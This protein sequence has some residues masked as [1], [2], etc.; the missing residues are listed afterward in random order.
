L[1][2][3]R[4]SKLQELESLQ[5]TTAEKMWASELQDLKKDVIKELKLGKSAAT[6][7]NSPK[8]VSHQE[9]SLEEL[10]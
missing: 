6:P 2:T 10:D 7:K 3:E 4:D 8:D 5:N 1:N 9:S